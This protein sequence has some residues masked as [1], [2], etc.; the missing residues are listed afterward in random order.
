MANEVRLCGVPRRSFGD[1]PIAGKVTRRPRRRNPPD[2]KKQSPTLYI[3][4]K[5]P[6][7]ARLRTPKAA[8]F[9]KLPLH[10][11]MRSG[12]LFGTSGAVSLQPSKGGVYMRIT[13][14]I[15]QFTVTII[16]KRRNR[17]PAR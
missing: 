16:V 12:T 3:I 7:V 5:P 13:L 10:D 4:R 6:P 9:T 8:I 15:G 14:H 11:T 17:H 1:F 2:R